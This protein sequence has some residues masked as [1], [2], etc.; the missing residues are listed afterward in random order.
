MV[1][2]AAATL[3]GLILM[4]TAAAEAPDTVFLEDLTWTEVRDAI[5]DGTTT[6]IVPT[7]G[8]E[9]NGPHAV[10]GKHK[11]RMNAGS[12]RIARELGNTLVA[13][14]IVYVPEG[15]IDP[16]TGHMRFAGTISIPDDVF[17][18]ILEA[19]AR[20]LRVHGFTDILFVGDSGGNQQG[21]QVVSEALNEEWADDPA[22]V[23][24]V[25]AWYDW[26][27]YEDW[28]REQGATDD[29]IGTHAGLSDTATLLAVAPHAVRQDLMTSGLTWEKD[30]VTGDPSKATVELGEIGMKFLVNDTLT[31][32]REF[33]AA[34][35]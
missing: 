19:T 30:G 17:R 5:A 3:C 21:M 10:L 11:Y 22:R 27:T 12:E 1:R 31:Q 18:G 4:A 28:L 23:H 15:D 6:I 7:A 14:I 33:L 16:P 32:I 20:S 25:S 26:T 35:N 9:Q 13:P 24:F 29:E 34:E 2:M 8:T